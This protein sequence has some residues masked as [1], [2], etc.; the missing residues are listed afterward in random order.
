MTTITASAS[1]AS[2]SLWHSYLGE[3]FKWRKHRL[4][5]ILVVLPLLV[6]VTLIVALTLA[7]GRA[8]TPVEDM[9]VM[10][11]SVDYDFGGSSVFTLSSLV[12]L[13][14]FGQFYAI[15]FML[16]YVW[17]VANEFTWK[18]IKMVATRQPS[19]VY[20]VLSKVLFTATLTAAVFLSFTAAWLVISLY[21]KW[22]YPSRAASLITAADVDAIG[23][24]LR[25]MAM[26]CLSQWIWGNFAAAVTYRG[27]SVAGGVIA[28]VMYS[29]VES[30]L[31]S[32]GA[33]ALN[34]GNTLTNTG[35]PI[36]GLF[37]AL[38][39]FCKRAYPFWLSSN[40]NRIMMV[41]DAMQVVQ[42]LSVVWSWAVIV[43]Y[44]VAFVAL[45]AVLF[46][47]RDITD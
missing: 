43:I 34:V 25:Y 23:K 18:T 7:G 13:R 11:P 6:A 24:G 10:I 29:T 32:I 14:W 30:G 19:R 40:V 15:A 5:Q 28:V 22:Y 4:Y 33:A 21:F 2:P 3:V 35:M 16:A 8:N 17:C 37:A 12:L 38:V 45:S 46:A 44:A 9:G 39:E 1:T 26:F 36:G 47:T 20:I 41:P 31:S 42:S 27:K